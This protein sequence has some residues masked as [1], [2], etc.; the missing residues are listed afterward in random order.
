[1]SKRRAVYALP[2]LSRDRFTAGQAASHNA[3]SAGLNAL[4]RAESYKSTF[5][6]Q[7]KA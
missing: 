7:Q 6:Q 2:R 5:S 1:M 4:R 3:G